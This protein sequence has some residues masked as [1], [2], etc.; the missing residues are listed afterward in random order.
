MQK[1]GAD[2]YIP[3]ILLALASRKHVEEFLQ[4]LQLMIDRHDV[5]RSAVLWENLPRPIQVV[6]R[7][8]TLPVEELVLD[9]TRDA[10]TQLEERM[11]PGCQRLELRR[12]PLMHVQVAADA[13]G[14][15]WYA[16]LRIH[17]LIHDQVS[18]DTMLAEVKAHIEGCGSSLPQPLPFRNHVA[19]VLAHSSTHDS[20]SYF[21]RKLMG[22]EEPTA[23]FGLLN[24]HGDGSQIEEVQGALDPALCRRVRAQ[25][26]T[27]A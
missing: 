12:A 6:Y 15:Q 26:N 13:S 2:T 21:R 10:L 9:P 19:Q 11:R 5:L 20:E 25:A 4:A 27:G 8:A 17:H 14:T 23:P 18:R 7:Q 24:V 22:V 16:L 1:Q 3:C